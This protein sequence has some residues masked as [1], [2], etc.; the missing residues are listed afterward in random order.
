M[1]QEEVD[2]C[3]DDLIHFTETGKGLGAREEKQK[4]HKKQKCRYASG[5]STIARKLPDLTPWCIA[6]LTRRLLP[7]ACEASLG[8]KAGG[9]ILGSLLVVYPWTQRYFESFGYL[10]S[11]CAIMGNL[12]VKAHGKKVLISFVKAVM[13]MDDLKGTFTML[14]DLYCNKLHVDPENF[15]L[16]SNVILIILATHFSKEFTLQ[17]QASWQE[18]TNAVA[19]AVALKG[20]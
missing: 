3:N 4:S 10:G 19:N 2:N 14:S 9:E 20:H 16:L 18:P 1:Q 15:L 17:I 11:D 13:L 5:S 7:L 12:K 6:L 8:E